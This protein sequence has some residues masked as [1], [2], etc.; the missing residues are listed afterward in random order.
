VDSTSSDVGLNHHGVGAG[1]QDSRI[2]RLEYRIAGLRDRLQ[3]GVSDREYD[4]WASVRGA[5]YVTH[6]RKKIE[7]YE[8]QLQELRS[9][10]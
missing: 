8:R 10:K 2:A 4:K 7:M 5:R 6:D 3:S 9:G 1:A